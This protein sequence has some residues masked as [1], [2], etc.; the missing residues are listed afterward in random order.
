MIQNFKKNGNYVFN[1]TLVGSISVPSQIMK[2]DT[3]AFCCCDSL[4]II[5]ITNATNQLEFEIN[6]NT[7][8]MIPA[9]SINHFNILNDL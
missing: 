5:E 7:I 8:L 9:Y 3:Y 6:E 1:R 4:Q 2:I